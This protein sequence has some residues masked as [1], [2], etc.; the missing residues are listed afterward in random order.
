MLK[1]F[2]NSGL[3]I[4]TEGTILIRILCTYCL[5]VL[6][7]PQY[8][9]CKRLRMPI[10]TYPDS[11][12]YVLKCGRVFFKIWSS[13]FC[14]CRRWVLDCLSAGN[15]LCMHHVPWTQHQTGVGYIIYRTDERT[16]LHVDDICTVGCLCGLCTTFLVKLILGG[17][18]YTF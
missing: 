6:V 11:M 3:L 14:V 7:K 13:L 4:G 5:H 12:K 1:A 9:L 15:M 8:I 16:V 10:L 2:F 18:S 17:K